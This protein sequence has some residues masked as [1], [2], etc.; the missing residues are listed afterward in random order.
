MKNSEEH[1]MRISK[2]KK[3]KRVKNSLWKPCKI[4]YNDGSEKEYE[5]LKDCAKD[6]KI[7]YNLVKKIV[8]SSLIYEDR[9]NKN[10]HIKGALIIYIEKEGD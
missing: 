6:N 2:S 10:P 5:N 9:Y 3:G 1:R 7:S 4:I 8:K